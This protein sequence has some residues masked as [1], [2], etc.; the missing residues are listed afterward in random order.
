MYGYVYKTTNLTNWQYVEEQ[1]NDNQK[2][3]P[4]QELP[5]E[6]LWRISR[7]VRSVSSVQAEACN[8]QKRRRKDEIRRKSRT[9][10][11]QA[12]GEIK[13]EEDVKYEN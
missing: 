4:L 6:R 9:L 11:D 13:G 2:P 12:D 10:Q 5:E 1:K 7:R 8:E 3:L